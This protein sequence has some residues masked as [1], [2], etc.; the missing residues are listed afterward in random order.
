VL[1]FS[2]MA[3]GLPHWAAMHVDAGLA[4]AGQSKSLERVVEMWL[5]NVPATLVVAKV[6][7]YHRIIIDAGLVAADQ[8]TS[9]ECI[10]EMWLIVHVFQ[11]LL[12]LLKLQCTIALKCVQ[13]INEQ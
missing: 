10:F 2:A 7:V 6:A 1:F 9:M 5:K 13:L 3:N 8:L 12:C 11:Q 4:A